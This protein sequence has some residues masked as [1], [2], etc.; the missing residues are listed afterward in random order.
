ASVYARLG[1]V[2]K[3]LAVL[4]DLLSAPAQFSPQMLEHH[5]RLRPIQDDP[6]FKALMDREK[7]RVF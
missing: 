1:E 6:R 4:E 5:F 2:D 3:A 7:D